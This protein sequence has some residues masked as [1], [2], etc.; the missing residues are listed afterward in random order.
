MTHVLSV[1]VRVDLDLH[2]VVLAIEGCL[3]ARTYASLLPVLA[4]A[5]ALDPVPRIALDLLGAQHVDLD[6]LLSLRRAIDLADPEQIA[7]LSVQVPDELPACPLAP[8]APTAERSE[9]SAPRDPGGDVDAAALPER[10]RRGL[11]PRGRREEILD[12][13]AEMIAEHGYHGSSLRDI[14]AH[15][16]ISH[17]G[18]MHHFPSKASLLHAV[19]DGLE[20]CAQQALEELGQLT[21][22]PESLLQALTAAWHP[23]SLPVRL[24]ATL[25][26]ETVS[27]DHPGRLRTAR[28]RRVHEHVLE[29]CFAAYGESGMLRRGLDPAF[30]SRA[31]LGLV[32]NLAV[33]EKTVRAMQG[34]THDDAPAQEIARLLRSFL[35]GDPVD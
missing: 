33:R 22:R 4:Q 35:Q 32:L 16:G 9:P 2:E 1:T 10:A 18:L 34:G 12:G 31:M 20:D 25:V 13:A 26:A 24:L 29:Q 14:A 11:A 17:P 15:I 6:G 21:D 23:S 3:T 8:A 7:P 19:L 27:G 28:L 5:R 30:A